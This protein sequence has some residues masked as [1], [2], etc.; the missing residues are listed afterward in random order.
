MRS[1]PGAIVKWYREL[2]VAAPSIQQ[3]RCEQRKAVD[4]WRV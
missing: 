3:R 1:P 4:Y 2:S